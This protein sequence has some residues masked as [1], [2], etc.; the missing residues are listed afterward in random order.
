MPISRP[1]RRS[2]MQGLSSPQSRRESVVLR[3]T[4]GR[5]GAECR[6]LPPFYVASGAV[7]QDSLRSAVPS[8]WLL[9]D[10]PAPE[11]LRKQRSAAEDELSALVSISSP[12]VRS[13]SASKWRS[14]FRQLR[15]VP[16]SRLRVPYPPALPRAKHQPS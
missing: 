9:V 15:L 14:P 16:R 10:G 5:S 8:S 2:R 11:H 13:S 4:C 7:G 6:L 12:C 1:S 3:Y